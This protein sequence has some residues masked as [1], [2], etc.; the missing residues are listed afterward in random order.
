MRTM[1]GM[2]EDLEDQIESLFT[3]NC[4]FLIFFYGTGISEEVSLI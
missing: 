4:F 2:I 1:N 3:F